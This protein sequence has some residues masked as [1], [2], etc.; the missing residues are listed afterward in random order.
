MPV[1]LARKAS[2]FTE[3]V[4]VFRTLWLDFGIELPNPSSD[5]GLNMIGFNN[6]ELW[7]DREGHSNEL[8]VI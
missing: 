8:E 4:G 1:L 3:V 6:A 5:G 2:F 7:D